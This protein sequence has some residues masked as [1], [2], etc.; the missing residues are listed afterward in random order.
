MIMP[1]LKAHFEASLRRTGAEYR[2]VHE[3][4]DAP[5]KKDERHD[6]KKI[7]EFG[8]MFRKSHGEEALREYILHIHDD[9]HGKFGHLIEDLDQA[10]KEIMDSLPSDSNRDELSRKLAGL[11]R[12]TDHA[13]KGILA[14]FGVAASTMDPHHT[15]KDED[16]AFL[17]QAGV[18]PEDVDHSLRVARKALDVARRTEARVDMEFVGR[19][20]LFHD[21]GKAQTHAIEHGMLGA[22]AGKKL[23]LPESITAIMEKHIRGGL[24]KAEAIELGLPVKDYS[25]KTLEE[26]IIIYA[27]RLVDIIMDGV[28][29]TGPEAEERF[30]EIM[31][32]NTRYGKNEATLQRYLGYHREIQG[33][34]RK[35]KSN[36]R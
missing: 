23:G 26:R 24:T 13:V 34:I 27:D 1:V 14:Y 9:V 10:V 29:K 5:G 22:E 36:E 21:L 35:E 15:I 11:V 28:V 32:T 16:V 17:R 2:D 20:A 31:S 3:F 18:S 7:H 8:E 30:E 25:L 4:V 12:N 33:L 19:A 6:I